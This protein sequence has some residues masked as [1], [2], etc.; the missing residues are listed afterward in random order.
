M[1]SFISIPESDFFPYL[2][3]FLLVCKLFVQFP[4]KLTSLQEPIY[5][6]KVQKTFKTN[7]KI[8]CDSRCRIC[9]PRLEF[10]YYQK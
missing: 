3:S 9:P 10:S 5:K 7:G 4:N 2:E 6:L 8:K 1:S